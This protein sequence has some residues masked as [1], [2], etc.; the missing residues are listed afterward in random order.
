LPTIMQRPARRAA[1]ARA[2]GEP[3]ASLVDIMRRVNEAH[4]TVSLPVRATAAALPERELKDD[5]RHQLQR[6]SIVNTLRHEG[7]ASP[8][9][10]I[11][12]FGAGD[13]A[14]SREAWRA[15]AGGRFCV[16]DKNPKRTLQLERARSYGG[17]PAGFMPSVVCADV[18][19]LEPDELRGAVEPGEGANVMLCNHL[20]GDALDEAVRCSVSAWHSRAPGSLAG[21]MAVTCCHDGC[22]WGS[23]LGKA[24][25]VRC[26]LDGPAEFEQLRRWSRLA[27]RRNVPSAGR[28]RVVREATRLGVS[29]DAAVQLGV[30]CRELLDTGRALHLQALGFEVAL[31]KHVDF[32]VTAD[33]V[34]IQAVHRPAMAAAST[35]TARAVGERTEAGPCET[36]SSADADGLFSPAELAA[37]HQMRHLSVAALGRPKPTEEVAAR[38]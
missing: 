19:E 31:V 12:E 28:E 8:A 25:L 14:L 13:A 37:E 22:S 9:L 7:L 26:G 27:P 15:Q 11:V 16:V 1:A 33:N 20:C 32:R 5:E 38:A 35:P 10:S 4:A 6:Q 2:P 29:C 23:Y 17:A 36:C 18:C 30:R 3:D 21:V 24:F 34:M